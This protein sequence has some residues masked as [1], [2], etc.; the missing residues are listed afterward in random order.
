M[1]K[2][3][4]ELERTREALGWLEEALDAIQSRPMHPDRLQMWS[5]GYLEDINMLKSRIQAYENAHNLNTL[6]H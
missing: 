1:I 2:D 5:D 6:T 4:E 3:E